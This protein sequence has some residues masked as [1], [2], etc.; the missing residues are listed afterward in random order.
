[1]FQVRIR[2]E[3]ATSGLT[4]I[5]SAMPG[6]VKS[7]M[8]KAADDGFKDSQRLVHVVTG[9]L[10]ASGGIKSS[11]PTQVTYGYDMHYAG[12]EEF[13][14]VYRLAHPYIMPRY[15]VLN[16]GLAANYVA[17]ALGSAL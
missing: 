17:Q 14:T 13:G 15:H 7:G 16:N 3:D 10:R 12:Y 8:T 1:M 5:A 11:T 2:A 4:R 6:A 9:K